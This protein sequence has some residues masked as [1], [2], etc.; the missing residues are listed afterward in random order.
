MLLEYVKIEQSEDLVREMSVLQSGLIHHLSVCRGYTLDSSEPEEG[1]TQ[2]A[3]SETKRRVQVFGLCGATAHTFL[4]DVLPVPLKNSLYLQLPC[5]PETW[6]ISTC[7]EFEQRR[8]VQNG[9]RDRL[10]SWFEGLIGQV[11]T[12]TAPQV[13][14]VTSQLAYII[15][16][17][18]SHR[19]AILSNVSLPGLSTQTREL[20]HQRIK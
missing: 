9:R 1:F 13:E 18:L 15:A 20:E 3:Q 16:A 8:T 12:E 19:V 14:D 2:W 7:E 11:D 4:F 5:S 6:A 17:L 10:F